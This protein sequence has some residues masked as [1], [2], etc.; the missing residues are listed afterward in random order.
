MNI[1]KI[2]ILSTLFL[3]QP[4]FADDLMD[5]AKRLN[6]QSIELLGI[7]LIA[8]NYLMDADLYS[9]LPYEHYKKNGDYKYFEELEKAGY[10]K[11]EI[12]GGLP[13]GTGRGKQIRLLPLMKGLEVQTAI[14]QP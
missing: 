11:I 10:I 1:C 2:L 8:L 13:D 7:N 14:K 3:S 5:K 4:L 6:N 9:Y 12:V